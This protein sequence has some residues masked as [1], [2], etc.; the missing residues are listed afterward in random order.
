M[1]TIGNKINV[2]GVTIGNKINIVTIGN[3]INRWGKDI[4]WSLKWTWNSGSS[5]GSSQ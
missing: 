2:D 1:G 3:K 4:R 5:E